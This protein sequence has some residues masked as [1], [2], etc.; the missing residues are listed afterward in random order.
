METEKYKSVKW[1]LLSLNLCDYTHVCIREHGPR[2][3]VYVGGGYPGRVMQRFGN[4]LVTDSGIYED[5]LILYVVPLDQQLSDHWG[6]YCN[7]GCANAGV[8]V[9]SCTG[10]CSSCSAADGV[11]CPLV[12]SVEEA[13]G[14]AARADVLP[15]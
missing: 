4:R 6:D 7:I 3:I 8:R 2:G 10:T 9:C 11:S 13:S 12:R 1:L 15:E 14:S 5:A